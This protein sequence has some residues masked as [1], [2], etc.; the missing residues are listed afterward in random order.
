[1]Q[2]RLHGLTEVLTSSFTPTA[3][4]GGSKTLLAR[5]RSG[6][7]GWRERRECGVANTPCIHKERVRTRPHF[8]ALGAPGLL[9]RDS[10]IYQANGAANPEHTVSLCR[11]PPLT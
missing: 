2:S 4:K 9:H 6:I 1:M 11:V 10:C 5:G 8:W 7:K 3:S